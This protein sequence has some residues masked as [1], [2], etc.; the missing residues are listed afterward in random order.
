MLRAPNEVLKNLL[1]EKKCNKGKKVSEVRENYGMYFL[2]C[3]LTI[4]DIE[5][6]FF[7][8]NAKTVRNIAHR[9]DIQTKREK[10][11]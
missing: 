1:S 11:I 2:T 7:F 6:L 4:L 3:F 5:N 9:T 8:K 10:Y